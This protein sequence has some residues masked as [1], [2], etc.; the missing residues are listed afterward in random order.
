M[1]LTAEDLNLSPEE[2]SKKI[3]SNYSG[4][5][6]KN[7]ELIGDVKKMS[8]LLKAFDGID[9]DLL[10]NQSKEL[11]KLKESNMTD[12]ERLEQERL[13]N[14][15]KYSSTKQALLDSEAKVLKMTKDNAVANA[16]RD[17]GQLNDG[18]GEAVSLLIS[19][20]ITL[21]DAGVP[22]VG[23]KTVT[24]YTKA[25]SEGDGKGFFVPKNSGGGGNGSGDGGNVDVAKFYKK[26]GPDY[27]LTE[28]GNVAKKDPELHKQLVK[29][30]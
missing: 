4:L 25:F 29:A 11:A 12:A 20:K 7:T 1:E 8:G 28:Q 24:E 18:M 19:Q 10:Q 6:D 23:D 14:T 2:L 9:L 22:M 13:A 3:S 30:K 5:T 21:S 26:D 16:L 15:E 17:A 27:S